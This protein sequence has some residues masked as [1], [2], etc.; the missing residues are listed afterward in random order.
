MNK[1]NTEIMIDLKDIAIGMTIILDKT[2]D[3]NTQQAAVNALYGAVKRIENYLKK[4]D[5]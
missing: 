4:K 2:R 1:Q 3:K 5:E